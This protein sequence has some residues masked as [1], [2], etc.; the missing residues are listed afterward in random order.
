MLVKKWGGLVRHTSSRKRGRM[1]NDLLGYRSGRCHLLREDRAFRAE[2]A[3]G[4]LLLDQQLP[5]ITGLDFAG[6]PSG[7]KLGIP[8]VL[9]SGPG[10]G[11]FATFAK[12]ARFAAYLDKPIPERTL[13]DTIRRVTTMAMS[14]TIG[15]LL[16]ERGQQ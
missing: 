16:L 13:V 6:S 8:L 14:F 10:N 5:G 3:R 2:P 11:T 4:C 9:M 15:V 7:K 12:R 1:E